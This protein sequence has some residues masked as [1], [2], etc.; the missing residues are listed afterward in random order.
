MESTMSEAI[1]QK[2]TKNCIQCNVSLDDTNWYP[3][4]VGKKHYKCKPCYDERRTLNRY[5]RKYGD[6]KTSLA[7]FIAHTNKKKFDTVKE[8]SIY[9]MFNP[10]FPGWVKVEMAVDAEDR[11]KQF[12]TSSPYRNYKLVKSYKVPNRREAEAKA[13]KALTIEGRGR[14]GEWFYMG[15]TVAVSE[16]DKLF[17]AGEQLE[18]F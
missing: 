11:I 9:I 4:F 10:S 13:H 3:S 16:L 18:L 1:G 15:S 12:Q 5:K 17:P 14:R 7:K 2:H 8:G 6:S